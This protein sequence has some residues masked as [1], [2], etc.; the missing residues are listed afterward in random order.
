VSPE[1]LYLSFTTPVTVSRY[2]MTQIWKSSQDPSVSAEN[3]C[4]ASPLITFTWKLNTVFINISLE[5]YDEGKGPY[6]Q[7]VVRGLDA[8]SLLGLQIVQDRHSCW[9]I[10]GAANHLRVAGSVAQCLAEGVQVS[11]NWGVVCSA[12]THNLGTDY[13]MDVCR[14]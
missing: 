12:V 1:I 2:L 13:R 11:A 10:D 9:H 6:P 3:S 8:A 7:V 14:D 5:D 4:L